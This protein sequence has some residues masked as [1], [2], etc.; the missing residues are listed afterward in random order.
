MPGAVT[1]IYSLKSDT[2]LQD[3]NVDLLKNYGNLFLTVDSLSADSAYIIEL[4]DGENVIHT[5]KVSGQ[6]SF[7][8]ELRYLRPAT[9]T[10]RLTEDWN[11]NGRWDSGHYDTYRQP[12]LMYTRDLEQLRANWDLEAVVTLDQMQQQA[13]QK[14]QPPLAR[15]EVT[16]I[17]STATDSTAVDTLRNLDNL[18]PSVRDR[19]EK[20]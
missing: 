19:I 16:A 6:T 10:V 2:I 1:D 15:P 5:Y 4:M 8:Q 20:N 18:P 13:R 9:F 14:R 3:I 11:G 7:G 12:E 17:D